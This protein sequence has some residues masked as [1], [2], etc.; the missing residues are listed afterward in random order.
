MRPLYSKYLPE[1]LKLSAKLSDKYWEDFCKARA[2][3]T[4]SFDELQR[5]KISR[6]NPFS[7]IRFSRLC[8]RTA[9]AAIKREAKGIKT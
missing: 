5:F 1:N 9:R 7:W 6:W 2:E 8:L 4:E 3:F